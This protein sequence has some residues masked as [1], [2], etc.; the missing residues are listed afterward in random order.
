MVLWPEIDELLTLHVN[1]IVNKIES[2]PKKPQSLNIHAE[3]GVCLSK[4]DIGV[5]VFGS[6]AFQRSSFFSIQFV[7]I[8]FFFSIICCLLR[9][10]PYHISYTHSITMLDRTMCRIN[11]SLDI[12]VVFIFYI[13]FSNIHS[14]KVLP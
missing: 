14:L 6:C 5:S 3:Y 12:C 2:K 9:G 13:W 1:F 4:R 8:T 10:M 7:G 11:Y